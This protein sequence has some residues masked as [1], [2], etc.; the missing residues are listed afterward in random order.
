MGADARLA[1]GIYP[2]I[3]R[4]ADTLGAETGK[5]AGDFVRALH[6]GTTDYDPLYAVT[7]Q[8]IND[9]GGSDAAAH[10]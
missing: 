8:I 3:Q 9:R 10:L 6:R 7:E 5:P 1:A 4:Q 2:N